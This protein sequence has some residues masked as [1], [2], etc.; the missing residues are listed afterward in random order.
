[1]R[2]HSQA[3]TKT[4]FDGRTMTEKFDAAAPSVAQM[5]VA[6]PLVAREA[7]KRQISVNT[8]M[9]TPIP[10]V[11]TSPNCNDNWIQQKSDDSSIRKFGVVRPND[12]REPE[13]EKSIERRLKYPSDER[14]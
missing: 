8:A 5:N 12:R 7:Y 1:M 3:T 6:R 10:S 13:N 9:M 2:P 4:M 11:S 14:N